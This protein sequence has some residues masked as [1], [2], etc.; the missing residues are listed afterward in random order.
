[1]PPRTEIE[2]VELAGLTTRIVG[3]GPITCVL[4][5]GFGAPGDD[6]VALA[7]YIPLPAATGGAAGV[8]FV[9]PAAPIELGGLYGD[10][11]AWWHLDLARLEQDLRT[12]AIRDRRG[13]IPTGLAEVRTQIDALLS[14]LKDRYAVDDSKLVLGGFSQGAMLALD[15]ALHRATAPAAV[16]L[17]SG[18][19]IAESEWRPLY[20]K[21]ANTPI[22]QSHGR[23]DSLLPFMI[24][25]LLRDDLT[26]A[27][28]KVEFI[29]FNGG[30]EIPPPVLLQAGKLLAQL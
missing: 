15:V 17:M 8:R 24:A 20:A 11:R 19:L 16:I 25:E 28:A 21:L 23:A 6:L 22:L 5:H 12:G 1:M 18:T 27:G 29:P 2:T 30:H 10:S 26:A 3:N 4:L 7:Q 9:F 13:E 14:A